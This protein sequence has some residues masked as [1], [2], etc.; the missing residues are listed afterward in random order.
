MASLMIG[1]PNSKSGRTSQDF[2]GNE[3]YES[4]DVRTKIPRPGSPPHMLKY[5]RLICEIQWRDP[6]A[7]ESGISHGC[8]PACIGQRDA[9]RSH[10]SQLR[11]GYS[12]CFSIG[13]PKRAAVF[14]LP[15]KTNR[16]ADGKKDS[17]NY[18]IL[19]YRRHIVNKC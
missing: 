18:L 7:I 1:K 5:K 2:Q 11:E 6:Q 15:F 9:E 3:V 8:R 16:Q 13:S 12:V 17:S 4:V 14:G 19:A 10:R